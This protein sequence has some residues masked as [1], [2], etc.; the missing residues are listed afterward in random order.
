MSI[1]ECA[2]LAHTTLLSCL[3]PL[4]QLHPLRGVAGQEADAARSRNQAQPRAPADNA[5]TQRTEARCVCPPAS[6]PHCLLTP[7]VPTGC[8]PYVVVKVDDEAVATTRSGTEQPK[9]VC[10]MSKSLLRVAHAPLPPTSF[11]DVNAYCEMPLG[12]TVLGDIT[13]EIWHA[14]KRGPGMQRQSLE[15][16]RLF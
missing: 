15:H 13:I 12:F 3:V 14:S 6:L 16:P 10:C 9:Y 4:H 2:S 1:C 8:R 5:V 11:L 7:L